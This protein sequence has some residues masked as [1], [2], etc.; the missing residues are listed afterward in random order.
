E[1]QRRYE[2][3]GREHAAVLASL[4]DACRRFSVDTDRV[5][6]SG[7]SAGGDAAWDIALAHPDLWAGAIPI[8]AVAD[9]GGDAPKYVSFYHKNARYVPLY[10][11]TGE[12][13]GNRLELNRRDFDR[14]LKQVD[15]DCVLIEYRG[16]GHEHF[17]DEIHHLFDWMKLHRRNATPQEFECSTMRPFDSFFWYLEVQGLPAGSIATPLAWADINRVR[18]AVLEFRK[19]A[20]NT[21]LVRSGAEQ[22]WLW[23]TDELINLS[24]SVM[25]DVNGNTRSYDVTPQVETI[26]E[27]ARTRVDRVR[28]FWTKLE[29]TTGKRNTR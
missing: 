18:P 16:R 13:D 17:Y 6:L 5:Y 24:G 11:V 22:A 8:V 15:T 27:D 9:Y 4:R 2:Y 19:N 3:T 12:L 26:L 1:S 10:F 23:L 20:N 7:H 21:L 14:Y 28:P 29:L 25:I